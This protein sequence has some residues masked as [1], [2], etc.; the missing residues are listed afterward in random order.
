MEGLPCRLRSES[1]GGLGEECEW[2]DEKR[3]PITDRRVVNKLSC[4]P[5]H[6]GPHMI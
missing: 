3:G 2:T 5:E 6:S 1:G 4:A